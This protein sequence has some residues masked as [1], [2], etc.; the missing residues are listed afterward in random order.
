MNPYEVLGV[1]KNTSPDD[2]KK[3][4]RKLSK[5]HHPDIEGGDEEKFKDIASAYD[6]LSTPEKKQQFD[7]Y[8]TIGG[9][10]GGGFPKMEDILSQMFGGNPFAR[11]K[12]KRGS[13][14][15]TI[16][17]MSLMDILLG[18]NKTITYTKDVKC[19]PCNGKGG[20]ECNKCTNCGGSGQTIRTMQ[21][22]FGAVQHAMPCNTCSSTGYVIKNPCKTCKGS[23]VT[24]KIDT[25]NASI[26][27]G[28]SNGMQL[29]MQGAGNNVRDGI[30][31][32]LIIRIEEIPDENFKRETFKDPHGND[33]PTN[34][35]THDLWISIS[36]AVL[37]TEKV[38]KAPLGDLK[39]N[40]EPGCDSGKVFK[41]TGKGI[42]VMSQD[43]RGY[44]AGN[45]LVKVNVRIPK[46][47]T[48]ETKALFEELKKYE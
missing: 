21:T 28:V 2:I 13:D 16:V 45:L 5:E 39:F 6:I 30:A 27:A 35:M 10:P 19:E 18:A 20:E 15:G 22:A 9:Q 8:G 24:P 12:S 4:Y 44:G 37:G 32:N 26:P 29:N 38:V 40:V 11:Q 47:V 42:P 41:F 36:E 48:D 1:D 14:I 17:K 7:N 31:G 23:G 3:A 34:N 46:K 43:G 33:V 25:V